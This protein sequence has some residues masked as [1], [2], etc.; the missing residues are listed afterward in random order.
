MQK[1][2][3]EDK[4]K[5]R[6]FPTTQCGLSFYVNRPEKTEASKSNEAAKLKEQETHRTRHSVGNMR[7]DK[8]ATEQETGTLDIAQRWLQ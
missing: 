2:Q 7:T 6:I 3:I 1:Y 4:Y 8:Q 5:E